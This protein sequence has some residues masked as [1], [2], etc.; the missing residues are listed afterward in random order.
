MVFN[1]DGDDIPV[2][3]AKAGQTI[4]YNDIDG[5]TTETAPDNGLFVLRIKA[6]PIARLRDTAEVDIRPV[7]KRG[8]RGTVALLTEKLKNKEVVFDSTAVKLRM[9]EGDFVLLGPKKY[10]PQQMPL[11]NLFF[12]LRGNFF[13][14]RTSMEQADEKTPSDKAAKWHKDIPLLRLYMIVCTRVKG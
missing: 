1:D 10:Y 11:S 14:P 13:F 9:S 8:K 6:K 12:T 7:C 4:S 5:I 2:A 3:K